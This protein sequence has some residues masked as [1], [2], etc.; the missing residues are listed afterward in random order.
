MKIESYERQYS[1]E[2]VTSAHIE[3]GEQ[4]QITPEIQEIVDGMPTE[5]TEF[6]EAVN[7]YIQD[8]ESREGTT[9]DFSRTASEIIE[10]E[11]RVHCHEAGLIRATLYRARGI[12][13]TYIQAL[14]KKHVEQYDPEAERANY[15]GHVFLRVNLKNSSKVINSTTGKVSDKLPDNFVLGGEGLDSWD[16]GLKNGG[17]DDLKKMFA[18]KHGELI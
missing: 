11:H 15:G 18:Q 3:T 1:E 6:L 5:E 9:P 17:I 8:L 14:R 16:I 7:S 12:Q 10:S 13:V 4:S 2:N